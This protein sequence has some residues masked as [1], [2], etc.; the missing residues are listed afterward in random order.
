MFDLGKRRTDATTYSH[1]TANKALDI[2]LIGDYI[3]INQYHLCVWLLGLRILFYLRGGEE[4]RPQIML[5]LIFV[6]YINI[7]QAGQ[8]HVRGNDIS[9]GSLQIA[10]NSPHGSFGTTQLSLAS[11]SI[12]D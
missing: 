7:T 4:Y 3:P 2:K 8:G 12:V 1:M 6:R 10:M 5:C 11:R 9:S